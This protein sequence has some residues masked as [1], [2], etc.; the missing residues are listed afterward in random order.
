LFFSSSCVSS[1]CVL[2]TMC[3]DNLERTITF[4]IPVYLLNS[5]FCIWHKFETN[6]RYLCLL[7]RLCQLWSTSRLYKRLWTRLCR[8]YRVEYPWLEL[9][10]LDSFYITIF[11]AAVL[12]DLVQHNLT[13]SVHSCITVLT[14]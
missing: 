4:K 5:L 12:Y 1:R 2:W 10:S 14:A 3:T 11:Y 7:F 8:F 6:E 9:V 13:F